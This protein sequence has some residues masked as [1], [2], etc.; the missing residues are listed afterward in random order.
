MASRAT[1]TADLMFTSV[2]NL[3]REIRQRRA[4]IKTTSVDDGN[5]DYAKLLEDSQKERN[6]LWENP[7][8]CGSVIRYVQDCVY[9]EDTWRV[10]IQGV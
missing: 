1:G 6:R 9:E 10:P 4:D 7:P 3:V 2:F 5:L 8:P